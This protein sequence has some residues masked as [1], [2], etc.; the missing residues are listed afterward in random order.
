M[1]EWQDNASTPIRK[2]KKLLLPERYK[3]WAFVFSYL[4]S[5]TAYGIIAILIPIYALSLRATTEQIGMIQGASGLGLMITILPA[6]FLIDKF[7]S[8]IP[9]ILSGSTMAII[10]LAMSYFTTPFFLILAVIM[11]GAVS[12][13]NMTSTNAAFFNNLQ[14][15]GEDK[16]G[17]FRGSMTVGV[18]LIGPIIGGFVINKFGFSATFVLI[19]ILYTIPALSALILT[20]TTSKARQKKITPL[21]F[22][23]QVKNLISNHSL[24]GV[25]FLEGI[26]IATISIFST[27]IIVL[28]LKRLGLSTQQ[29]G[30]ILSFEG[31]GYGSMLFF[32]QRILNIASRR[33]LIFLSFSCVAG[34][35][36]VFSLTARGFIIIALGAIIL[37]LALGLFGLISMSTLAKIK[38]GKGSVVGLN[39]FFMGTFS[40]IGPVLAGF[41]GKTLGLE[42][43]FWSVAFFYC[44]LIFFFT[45]VKL[46]TRLSFLAGHKSDKCENIM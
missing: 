33:R 28:G 39:G 15:M 16:T 1:N 11:T 37:G 36:L 13:F 25:L 32:G 40:T 22:F 2:Q 43:I 38:A 24:R 6:G 42:A 19:A 34:A 4:F 5:G 8:R 26:G 17:W 20:N 3:I 18:S 46:N 35:F 7:G 41:I 14:E 30:W 31:I 10:Y 27:F 12:S 45:V 44:F 23:P 21:P 29:T 9:Y